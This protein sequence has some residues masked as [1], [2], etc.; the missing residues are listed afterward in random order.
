MAIVVTGDNDD[1]GRPKLKMRKHDVEIGW[2]KI[3]AE[4]HGAHSIERQ[5][6]KIIFDTMGQSFWPGLVSQHT[7]AAEVSA[8]AV[9]KQ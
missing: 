8:R 1:L 9:R 5:Q 6:A 3:I 2:F 7:D 4:R